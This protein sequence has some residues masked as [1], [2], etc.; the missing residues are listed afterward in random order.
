MSTQGSI[1]PRL[2]SRL[3]L[4]TMTGNIDHN[5]GEISINDTGRLDD[6]KSMTATS[7]KKR[8]NL[9]GSMFQRQRTGGPND[10]MEDS[11]MN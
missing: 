3:Q 8:R 1:R 2:V 5:L 10:L 11:I 4:S 9:N 7:V 6:K